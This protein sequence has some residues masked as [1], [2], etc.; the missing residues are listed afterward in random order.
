MARNLLYFERCIF[1]RHVIR[2]R[3][4][5]GAAAPMLQHTIFKDDE[6]LESPRPKRRKPLSTQGRP[7]VSAP[8]TDPPFKVDSA[9]ERP[10]IELFGVQVPEASAVAALV[11]PPCVAQDSA[12]AWQRAATDCRPCNTR[13]MSEL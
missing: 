9:E 12:T 8:F 2:R 6:I 7:F 10:L 1:F 4:L 11:P 3:S 5:P 13:E